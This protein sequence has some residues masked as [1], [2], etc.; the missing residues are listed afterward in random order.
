MNQATVSQLLSDFSPTKFVMLQQQA[1][2]PGSPWRGPGAKA[3][4]PRAC[5]RLARPEG[6]EAQL[7][8]PEDLAWESPSSVRHSSSAHPSH[9]SGTPSDH[10][11]APKEAADA[12]SGPQS[13]IESV[14]GSQ[15]G[16]PDKGLGGSGRQGKGLSSYPLV[17]G[18]KADAVKRLTDKEWTRSSRSKDSAKVSRHC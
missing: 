15:E 4:S 1:K 12:S 17:F 8:E 9:L 13:G 2:R 18:G 3:P 5:P 6:F 11:A 10:Q 14:P 16:S 7:L